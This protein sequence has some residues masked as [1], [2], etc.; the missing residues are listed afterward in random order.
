[1]IASAFAMATKMSLLLEW[2]VLEVAGW[3]VNVLFQPM[4]IGWRQRFEDAQ[5]MWRFNA[6]LLCPV[7]V[8]FGN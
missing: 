8:F 2:Y 6:K 3:P 4:V 5:V 1:L 7:K